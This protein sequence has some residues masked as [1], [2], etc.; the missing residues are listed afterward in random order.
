MVF[1][2][3]KSALPKR[4]SGLAKK[5]IFFTI[6]FSSLLT[7][8]ITATQLYL[9]YRYD[10]NII[11]S[12]FKQ[13]Q[14][15]HLTSIANNLW[16]AD[17]KELLVQLDGILKIP[18]I[19]FLEIMEEDKLWATAGTKKTKNIKFRSYKLYFT[20]KE[21]TLEIGS[22]NVHASLDNVYQ[23]IYDKA[24][25]VL[26]SNGIKTSLVAIFI[27]FLFAR[28][29]SRHLSRISDYVLETTMT[30][31][32]EALTLNRKSSDNDE[33]DVVV[34]SINRMRERI[35]GQV[36]QIQQQK[37]YL[38]IMLNSIGDAVIATDEKGNVTHMNPE[39]EQLTGW[40]LQEAR[41]LPLKTI[42][43]IIHSHTQESIE[44][45]IDE[46]MTTGKTIHLRNHTTL[47][48]K[49]GTEFQIADSAAPI[50][51]NGHILGMVLVFNDVTE[52]YR[53]RETAAKSRR[54][55]QSIMDNSPAV[56]YVKDVNG[57]FTFINK[58]FEE[59][60]HTKTNTIIGKSLHDVFPVEIADEMQRND[61]IVI[62]TGQAHE[63]E[64]VAPQ[65]DG[66]HTYVSIKFPLYDD[67][68]NI[69]AVCGISTDITQRMQQDE[70]LRHS[71][72][73][74][75]LGNLTGG[76]AHDYNNILGIVMGYAEQLRSNLNHDRKLEKYAQGIQQAAERGAQLTKKILSFSRNHISRTD[77]YDINTL[78]QDMRILL[79]RT[80]TIRIKL[81]YDLADELWMTELDSD[82]LENAVINLSINAL[83]AMS[84]GGELIIRT[85]NER[86]N[87]T[88]ATQMRLEA[89]DYVL[90]SMTDTGCGMDKIT[91]EKIFDPFYTTKGEL[92]TGLGLSQVYGFVERCSGA[93]EVVT[94]PRHGSCFSLYFPKSKQTISE[95]P[96]PTITDRTQNLQG[97]ETLLVVDD[98]QAMLELAYETLS[99][100][101]YQVLTANDGEQALSVL[102]NE[103]VDL[104]ISDVIMPNMDGYQL[105]AQIQQWYPH[106]IM[107][108]VSG[109]ADE[110][111][112]DKE[113]SLLHKTILYKPYT[114]NALLAC[115]RTQLDA[116]SN[117]DKLT[118]RRVMVMDDEE[119]IRE[120]YKLRLNKLGCK[121]I[122]TSNGE[123]AIALYQQS[124][125]NDESIDVIILDLSIPGGMGGT[126]VAK[127]IW[128]LNPHAKIIVASGHSEAPEMTQ[129]QSYGFSAAIEKD[130]GQAAIK[131]IL[132]QVL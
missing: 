9:G 93:I 119:D 12:R 112:H 16:L 131:S 125:E 43:H 122:L 41:N 123:D 66:N 67:A 18:D 64:E 4:R 52:E 3:L 116:S 53:L 26:I 28:L 77:I 2:K 11:D 40:M 23:N 69:Y 57:R 70:Q 91:K 86:I 117:K 96:A 33:L 100:H 74:D 5:L 1:T 118:G 103:N 60:F 55:F 75:A 34:N 109:F 113:N 115:V 21:K 129:Y 50:T 25:I 126:E 45:P 71:Q 79:E 90:L 104:I 106:I 87:A 101:G 89:G 30:D 24:W 48:A 27:L 42:F 59:L 78:L 65:D 121:A 108:M 37:Q 95:I 36:N 62:E 8:I 120:L 80:L 132:E 7:L 83:H 56:I 97:S 32:S 124:L 99:T 63:S 82:D 10:L 105:A 72:K 31:P 84:N 46:V 107:L 38:S 20:Y 61:R 102:E 130:D 22:L 17:E 49:N 128:N 110:R 14:D 81:I 73:M 13:I 98:E 54:N 6:L 47:I 111:S 15:V 94:E 88:S 85:S 51:E 39:A 44:N 68:N 35:S 76:I 19:Q 127:K 58:K 29:I 114:S 92:G